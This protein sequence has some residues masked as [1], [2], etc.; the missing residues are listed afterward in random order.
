MNTE[1]FFD[2]KDNDVAVKLLARA[3]TGDKLAQKILYRSLECQIKPI[4][5]TYYSRC[6][7]CGISLSD[8]DGL[9][10]SAF[11]I[12]FNKYDSNFGALLTY[13]KYIYANLIKSEIRQHL[14]VTN[15]LNFSSLGYKENDGDSESYQSEFISEDE[16]KKYIEKKE[17]FYFIPTLEKI[18]LTSMEMSITRYYFSGYTNQEISKQMDIEYDKVARLVRSGLEKIKKYIKFEKVKNKIKY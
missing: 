2:A 12:C 15:Y 5:Y 6:K 17:V 10:S 9:C 4:Q 8:L 3:R 7:R 13:Y 1:N 14:Q 11:L 18:G 16:V